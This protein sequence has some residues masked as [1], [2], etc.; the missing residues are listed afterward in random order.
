MNLDDW[1]PIRRNTSNYLRDLEAFVT[2]FVP[3]R[4]RE[5]PR[6]TVEA[7][8]ARVA[9]QIAERMVSGV[10]IA[11]AR[12]WRAAASE[13]LHGRRIFAALRN[14]M[15]GPV[16]RRVEELISRNARLIR[17][18]PGSIAERITTYVA[19][20]R[21]AGRRAAEIAAALAA[22]V[23]QLAQ[24]RARLIARTETAKAETALTEA[25]A[26]NLG[27][28]YYE[29]ATSEDQRVRPSHR[30]MASVLVAWSDAPAPEQLAGEKSQLGHYHPGGAPNCRC[31][32]LPLI[33]L[34]EVRWPHQVYHFGQ[35]ERVDRATFERWSQIPRIA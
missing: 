29:W 26:E 33:A 25:R 6:A 16:G 3:W 23:P 31:L 19:E 14:E 18:L 2:E 17:E 8:I 10:A 12:S 11:N 9:R 5:L 34:D 28:R 24:S 27:L 7:E 22:K 4:L 35:I 13:S 21:L 30:L 1:R 15:N 20:E 32:A